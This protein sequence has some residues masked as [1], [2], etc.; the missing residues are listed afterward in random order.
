MNRPGQRAEEHLAR[1]V[2]VSCRLCGRLL[3]VS[4]R[5]SPLCPPCRERQRLL[6]GDEMRGEIGD[7][8]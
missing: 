7:R 4:P 2:M 5:A 1:R 8:K 3:V 6:F